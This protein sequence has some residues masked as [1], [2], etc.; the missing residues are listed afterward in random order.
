VLIDWFTV[1]AQALNFVILVWLMKRFLYRPILRA[2]DVREKRIAAEVADAGAKKAEAHRERDELQHKNEE[3][4]QQRAALLQ[5]ATD[6][7]HA[8]RQRLFGE[9]RQAADTLAAKREEILRNDATNLTRA[10][11][12]QTQYEVF[13]IARKVLTDL[14]TTSLEERLVAVFTRRLRELDGPTKAGLAKALEGGSDSALLRSAFELPADQRAVIQNSLNETFSANVQVRFE[15]AP[16]LV[17]GIE[18]VTGGQKVG[19]N[20]ADYLASLEKG[21]DRLVKERAKIR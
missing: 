15:T 21:V 19:W 20:I 6:D 10:I 12:R 7:A 18:L 4:D 9:A 8:E 17:S 14:A 13:A 3:L 2:V 5:K 16:D 1:G 11:Q